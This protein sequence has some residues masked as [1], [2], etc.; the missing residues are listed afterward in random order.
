MSNS[1]THGDT[2][3]STL[4][5]RICVNNQQSL[6]SM[7]CHNT[8]QPSEHLTGA[9]ENHYVMSP[10]K[11]FP[12]FITSPP[13]MQ[14]THIQMLPR[15][16]ITHFDL[17][18]IDQSPKYRSLRPHFS[19]SQSDIDFSHTPQQRLYVRQTKPVVHTE[20]T[21]FLRVDTDFIS[22]A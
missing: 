19:I 8:P 13:T 3:D 7:P 1:N 10:D 14:S 12:P 15:S 16:F 22:N 2:L 9:S 21:K 5:D 4:V 18:R 11:Q 6:H 17:Q 20:W